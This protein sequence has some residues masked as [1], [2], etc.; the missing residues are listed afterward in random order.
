MPPEW[1]LLLRQAGF[2]RLLISPSSSISAR[3]KCLEYATPEVFLVITT[4]GL[5]R[6]RYRGLGWLGDDRAGSEHGTSVGV[7]NG[8]ARRSGAVFRRVTPLRSHR[9]A[10]TARTQA[11]R[12]GADKR[13]AHT[14]RK[15]IPACQIL[16]P[17]A[18]KNDRRIRLF[19]YEAR[20][21]TFGHNAEE[22]SRQVRPQDFA[23]K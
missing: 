13:G 11:N 15:S 8:E 19:P 14:S 18:P 22:I 21:T 4:R 5:R 12:K 7:I 6:E 16:A 17:A 2:N 20:V 3:V 1:K 9:S 23:G 10:T